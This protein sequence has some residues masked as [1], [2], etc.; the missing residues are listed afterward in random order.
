MN[1]RQIDR[2]IAKLRKEADERLIYSMAYLNEAVMKLEEC[3]GLI[4][5]QLAKGGMRHE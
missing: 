2:K 5:I 3:R 1:K 4:K